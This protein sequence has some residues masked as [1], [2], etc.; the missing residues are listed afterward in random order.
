VLDR[1][2]PDAFSDEQ[3]DSLQA[4]EAE[5]DIWFAELAAEEEEEEERGAH[6]EPLEGS[7]ITPHEIHSRS[8]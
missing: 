5:R 8:P 1:R 7:D 3:A 6:P 4:D 2:F